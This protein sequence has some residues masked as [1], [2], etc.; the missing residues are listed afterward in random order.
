MDL[1]AIGSI[2]SIISLLLSII[3]MTS[4]TVRNINFVRLGIGLVI[5]TAIA[6]NS[7]VLFGKFSVLTLDNKETNTLKYLENMYVVRSSSGNV[8]VGGKVIKNIS[9]IRA[10]ADYG[11]AGQTIDDDTTRIS[12]GERK[13]IVRGE[14]Q[15]FIMLSHNGNGRMFGGGTGVPGMDL[16]CG[17]NLVDLY[18]VRIA[19]VNQD[20]AEQH[21]NVIL[22]CVTDPAVG[23]EIIPYVDRR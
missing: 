23:P 19:I 10:F 12:I 11:R 6:L 17:M 4:Q 18:R 22:V 3:P 2:A 15:E 21:F 1:N 7:V 16:S 13:D 14:N 8:V 20:D 9:R 5:L